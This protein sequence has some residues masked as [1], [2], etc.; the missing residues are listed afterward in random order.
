MWVSVLQ[1]IGTGAGLIVAIGAQNAFVLDRGLRREH[2]WHVAWICALCDALLIGLGMLGL[3]SLIARSQLAIQI[4]C[5]GGAAFLLWQAWLAVQRM[6]QPEGLA[7]KASGGYPARGQVIVATLAVTLLNPHVYL[8]TLVM[9]GSIG[10][11]Q[12]DPLGFYL[13]ASL[14]SFGWFFALVGAAGYLAP[15]L[16]SPRAWRIIDGTIALIMVLVAVQLL[17]MELG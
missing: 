14:A 15:R 3:G 2:A 12:Q 9:L 1:G 7:V 16:A 6:R 8:D 5:Y 4:A 10:S 17:N 11:L 13:G